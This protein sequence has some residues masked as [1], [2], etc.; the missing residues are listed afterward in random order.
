MTHRIDNR[1]DVI[2][3]RDVIERIAE[4]ESEIEYNE[5]LGEDERDDLTDEKEEL[6][7]LKALAEEGAGYSSDWLYGET[8]I[9]DSYWVEYVEEL[10]IDVGDLPKE[11]PQYIVIDWEATAENIAQDYVRIDFDGAEYYMRSC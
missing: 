4:L 7:A 11:L 5:A 8:L 3:S 10:V 1:Q 9:R 2:D 6:A